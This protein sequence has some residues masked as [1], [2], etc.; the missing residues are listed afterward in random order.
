MFLKGLKII[1]SSKIFFFAPKKKE[2]LIFD[3][4]QK[5]IFQSFLRRKEMFI[6]S[7]RPDRVNEIFI[8][9]KLIFFV[10]RNIFKRSLKVNYLIAMIISVN[11][12]VVVTY[13]DNSIDFYIISTLLHT[14][15]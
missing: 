2:I 15:I 1:F 13:T 12:K 9:P 10:L 14:Y 5:E 6:L 7:T 11:P 8:F 3:C 4:I